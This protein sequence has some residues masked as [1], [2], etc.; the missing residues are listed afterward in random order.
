MIFKK[1]R[2]TE[3]FLKNSI[4]NGEHL[5]FSRFL[6]LV[7]SKL[8]W[9][10]HISLNL[11]WT[12]EDYQVAFDKI[13]DQ[14]KFSKKFCY[15]AIKNKL[16]SKYI[17]VNRTN[18]VKTVDKKVDKLLEDFLYHTIFSRH[19]RILSLLQDIKKICIYFRLLIFSYLKEKY[20]KKEI[21][22]EGVYINNPPSPKNGNFFPEWVVTVLENEQGNFRIN[23]N[24]DSNLFL[25]NKAK[26]NKN[27]FNF[28]LEKNYNKTPHPTLHFREILKC[29][30]FSLTLLI[31]SFKNIFIKK[32]IN[33]ISDFR[34]LQAEVFKV[35]FN[36]NKITTY[37]LPFRGYILKE[38]WVTIAEKYGKKVINF[39]YSSNLDVE[40]P[41]YYLFDLHRARLSSVLNIKIFSKELLKYNVFNN[42][43]F[44]LSAFTIPPVWSW[45][46]NQYKSS[47]FK[48][49][50]AIFDI[51]PIHPFDG[52]GLQ[53][54]PVY[55]RHFDNLI[56]FYT[57]FFNDILS[58]CMKKNIEV[59]LKQKRLNNHLLDEYNNLITDLQVIY[60]NLIVL[61][62]T[63]STNFITANCMGSL[64]QCMTS[65]PYYQKS[66]LKNVFYDPTYTI[67]KGFNKKLNR[68]IVSGKAD[69]SKW[70]KKISMNKKRDLKKQKGKA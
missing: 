10:K 2:S 39:N 59:V 32:N 63:N 3:I 53:Y 24:Q 54:L 22:F 36:R 67:K 49:K 46:C 35:T 9:K 28:V 47:F 43:N 57:V 62:P 30:I 17:N 69:L 52:I 6:N 40:K 48:N 51:S 38:P 15:W 25:F 14:G 33:I 65:T 34:L 16:S 19:S 37:Y 4:I 70:I 42:K 60:P 56:S 58:L 7:S 41:G 29:I 11:G 61:E 50:I 45:T 21:S 26:N 31:K 27:K 5:I 23:T 68:N 12:N 44:N 20:S 13:N 55:F 1:K 18:K 8:I 64:S 66:I